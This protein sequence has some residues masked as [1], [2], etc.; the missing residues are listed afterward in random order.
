MIQPTTAPLSIEDWI[1]LEQENDTKYEYYNGEIFAMAGGSFNHNSICKNVTRTV[2]NALIANG[3]R[4]TFH[5]SEMKLELA[6]ASR[7]VYTDGVITCGD[8]NIVSETNGMIANPTVIIEVLSPTSEADDR[9]RKWHAYRRLATLQHYLL[10]SQQ[11]PSIELYSRRGDLWLFRELTELSDVI[12]LDK[13]G[14]EISLADLYR[15]INFSTPAS[16]APAP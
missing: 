4:C 7:Y 1:R 10:I 12:V 16:D 13:V 5:N 11:R 3:D 14:I 15:R 2:E 9:G 6:E 8:D